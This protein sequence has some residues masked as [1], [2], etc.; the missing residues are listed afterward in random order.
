MRIVGATRTLS[1]GKVA[2]VATGNGMV[3]LKRLFN[4]SFSIHG[5][6]EALAKQKRFIGQKEKCTIHYVPV[7]S[8][9]KRIPAKYGANG[10]I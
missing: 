1:N 3:T 6:M 2:H 8:Q 9:Q 7:C 5:Q 4:I 10:V